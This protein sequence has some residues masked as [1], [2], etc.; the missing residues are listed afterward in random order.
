[1]VDKSFAST[2]RMPRVDRGLEAV[3]AEH[4][5]AGQPRLVSPTGEPSASY[6]GKHCLQGLVIFGPA[7]WLH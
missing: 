1:M 3:P 7:A 6:L 4:C 2:R 5:E